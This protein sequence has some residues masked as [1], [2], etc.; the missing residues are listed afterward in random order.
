[1]ERPEYDTW[2]RVELFGRGGWEPAPSPVDPELSADF[3]TEEDAHAWAHARYSGLMSSALRSPVWGQWRVRR[4][5]GS[6]D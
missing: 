3:D 6:Q 5:R 1:M 2:F 4:V